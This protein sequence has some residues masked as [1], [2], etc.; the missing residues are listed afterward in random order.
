MLA[1]KSRASSASVL[2]SMAAALECELDGN[3]PI[4]RTDVVAQ[5]RRRREA[6]ALRMS[7]RGDRPDAGRRRWVGRSGPQAPPRRR[8]RCRRRRRSRQSPR[9]DTATI[10]DVPLG[11]YDAAL[12]CT[13]DEP[14]IEM[15]DYLLGNGKH[16]LVEKPLWA[17]ASES[18]RPAAGDGAATTARSA[19]PPTTIA[20]SR[21]SCACA[22]LIASGELGAIYRCRMFYGNG[23]ARL[24][25][26]FGWRD[27][28]AGV[29][30]DLGSHLLDTAQLLVRRPSP[31][32]SAIV[33]SRSFREPRA[34]S[35]GDWRRENRSRSSSWR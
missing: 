4:G 2:G 33:S 5:D 11:D 7:R 26:E 15:L 28:G 30:P 17:P 22:M 25:R 6:G 14:K 34:R 27:Q 9:R 18:D 32:I 23:T 10:A 31:R 13:P 24:V 8:Q 3:V 1:D 12:V 16:V 29:L 35:R 21:I 19:T 20:S